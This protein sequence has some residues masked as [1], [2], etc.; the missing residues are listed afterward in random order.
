MKTE[1]AIRL[2]GKEVLEEMGIF[3][4]VRLKVAK[5]QDI[6]ELLQQGEKCKKALEHIERLSTGNIMSPKSLIEQIRQSA[7]YTLLGG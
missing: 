3:N 6:T 4:S 5:A 7:K 2:L 1:E